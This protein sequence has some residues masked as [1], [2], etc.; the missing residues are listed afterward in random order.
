MAQ[1][2]ALFADQCRLSAFQRLSWE[3]ESVPVPLLVAVVPAL[4]RDAAVEFHVT[5]VQDGSSQAASGPVTTEVPCGSIDWHVV[6]SADACSASLSL[7]LTRPVGS[8]EPA[9][10][11][12]SEVAEAIGS[13]LK[14]AM[15]KTNGELV[16]LCARVFYKCTH[17]MA[18]LIVEGTTPGTCKMSLNYTVKSLYWFIFPAIKGDIFPKLQ[19]R[20]QVKLFIAAIMETQ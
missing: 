1:S 7:S 18:R 15:K 9:T 8:L 14:E 6:T 20:S 10:A 17:A 12:M 4:P 3:P 16:P 5:A 2:G 11:A 19:A 13:T